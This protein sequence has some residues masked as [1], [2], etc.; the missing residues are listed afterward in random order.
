MCGYECC[1]S[2]KSTHYSLISWQYHYLEKLM[3]HIQNDQNRRSGKKKILIYET[4]KNKVMP[5]GR[6]IYAKAYDMEKATMFAYPQSNHSFPHWKCTLQCCAKCPSLNI[7]DQEINY[8]YP[9]TSPSISFH[10]YHLIARCSTHVRLPINDKKMCRK[11]K[12]DDA[13]EQSTKIYTRK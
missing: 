1:I 11:F 9:N 7:S 5:H 13:S 12:Q 4:Y 8:Q 3:D 6:H 2:D 10:V